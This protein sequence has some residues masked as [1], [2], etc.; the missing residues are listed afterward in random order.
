MTLVK[1]SLQDPTTKKLFLSYSLDWLLVVTM[2]VVFFA[3]DILPPFHREFSIHDTTIMHYY[4]ESQTVSLWMLTVIAL[5]IPTFIIC[6]VSLYFRSSWLDFHSGLLG[7]GLALSMTIMMTDVIKV[8]VGRP[9]PD[10]L[11]R[12]QPPPGIE[13]PVLHLLNYTICTAD[14]N[15]YKFKDG[16]K[17]F[18]SGHSSF[19]FAGLGYLAFYL[20]GKM[21]IFDKMGHAYK[22]FVF[23]FPFVG[24]SLVAM[25]RVHD[26]RHHWQD[27]FVGGLIGVA[28]S[29]FSYRQYYPSLASLRC[30]IPYPPRIRNPDDMFSNAKY[31]TLQDSDIEANDSRFDHCIYIKKK[32]TLHSLNFFFFFIDKDAP[33]SEPSSSHT[34]AD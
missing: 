5:L 17:S 4:T 23:C 21:H 24:A 32:V 22:S 16:F 26:Y 2:T 10:M 1:F 19:S 14:P 7:L 31:Q 29:Y 6:T 28:S 18:P 15:T 27:V 8:C 13:D 12:C 11:D 20:A 25:S 3:I 30:Q 9:R 33:I 34:A